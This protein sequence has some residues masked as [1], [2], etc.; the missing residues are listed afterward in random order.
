MTSIR[1]NVRMLGQCISHLKLLTFK[2]WGWRLNFST[3][4]VQ[5]LRSIWTEKRQ[6]YEL[7]VI[8]W[9]IK[10]IMQLVLKMKQIFVCLNI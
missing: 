4:F 7:K 8:L 1:K 3:W 10:Q 5:N 2:R 9:K 6:N